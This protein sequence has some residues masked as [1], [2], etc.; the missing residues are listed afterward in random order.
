MG[1]IARGSIIQTDTPRLRLGD[2]SNFKAGVKTDTF[3][4]GIHAVID[5]L[6]SG[7]MLPVFSEVLF[8]WSRALWARLPADQKSVGRSGGKN[9]VPS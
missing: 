7:G 2:V 5:R 8:F 6:R 4:E 3:S 1:I 9:Q